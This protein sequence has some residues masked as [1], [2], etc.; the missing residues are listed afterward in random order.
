LKLF[1]AAA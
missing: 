1:Q